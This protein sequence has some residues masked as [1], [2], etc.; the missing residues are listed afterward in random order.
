MAG[1]ARAAQAQCLHLPSLALRRSAA[2]L[3]QKSKP[4]LCGLLSKIGKLQNVLKIVGFSG[5]DFYSP[6]DFR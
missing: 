1:V 5:T 4:F 3:A 2:S 6:V